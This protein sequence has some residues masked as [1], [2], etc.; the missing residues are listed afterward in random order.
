MDKTNRPYVICHMISSIDGKID[1]EFFGMPEL[2]P[3]LAVSH[4][5]RAEYG[6]KAVLNGAVTAAE[7]YADEFRKSSKQTKEHFPREDM[8][9]KTD[10]DEFAIAVDTEGR[11]NWSKGYVERRGTK[12]HVIV[13]LTE[14]VGDDYIA[15]LR[16]R[17]ISYLFAGKEELE[18]PLMLQKLRSVFGI[19]KLLI[20]GGGVLNW[21][22][23]QAGCIDEF[24]LVVAPITDGMTNTASLFERSPY[25]SEN[26]P[27]VF[28]LADVKKLPGDG[29]WLRYFPK[30]E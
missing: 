5:I 29:V 4:K 8:A 18:I 30:A 24:S 25:L 23:L 14:N 13:V 21:S 6:C 2:G 1:G 9:V 7:I 26:V 27:K 19:E 22:F 10:L 3:V 20:S 17:R 12:A 15:E 11:L 16:E 28:S